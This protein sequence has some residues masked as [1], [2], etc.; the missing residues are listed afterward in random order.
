MKLICISTRHLMAWT[1]VCGVQTG[2]P[3]Q[4]QSDRP[5][6]GSSSSLLHAG[7]KLRT[8]DCCQDGA[9][10]L[11][12]RNTWHRRSV[13]RTCLAQERRVSSGAGGGEALHMPFTRC[14]P[15]AGNTGTSERSSRRGRAPPGQRAAQVPAL[16]HALDA[17]GR[18]AEVRVPVGE[19]PRKVLPGRPHGGRRGEDAHLR[20]RHRRCPVMDGPLKV[21][22]AA[23]VFED[24][25]RCSN[26]SRCPM[27]M[28]VD[29]A[30]HCSDL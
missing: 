15:C 22:T 6:L 25:H 13:A 18:A 20:R 12:R 11:K 26:I 8:W 3:N 4:S 19:Q 16:G 1:R 23:T 27:K 24:A 9:P 10:L 2:R 7:N 29:G 28:P 14:L 30:Q 21:P 5:A 17:A